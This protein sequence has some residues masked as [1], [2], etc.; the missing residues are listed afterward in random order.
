MRRIQSRK[1]VYAQALSS[2]IHT[3]LSFYTYPFFRT[4]SLK[5]GISRHARAYREYRNRCVTR[6]PATFWCRYP[7]FS[8][9]LYSRTTHRYSIALPFWNFLFLVRADRVLDDTF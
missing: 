9:K 1:I 5:Y 8:S 2:D 3:K 7:Y 4:F 6:D